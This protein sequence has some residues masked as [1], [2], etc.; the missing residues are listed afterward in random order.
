[1]SVQALFDAV[2]LAPDLAGARCRGC[3]ALFDEP[4]PGES[5]DIAAMRHLQ[6]L[7]LCEQCPALTR[8]EDWLDTLTPSRRPEG[9]IAGQVI[10]T[11]VARPRRSA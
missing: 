8:C 9:V 1:M 5:D 11:R 7:G 2:G 3:S 4:A 10:R 6:A